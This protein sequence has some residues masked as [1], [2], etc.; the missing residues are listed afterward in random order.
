MTILGGGRLMVIVFTANTADYILVL[1][2]LIDYY[3]LLLCKI[4]SVKL[5]HQRVPYKPAI[6]DVPILSREVA[7]VSR[8]RKHE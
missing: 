5:L 8:Q 2:S 7:V 4:N 3:L 1:K 6:E